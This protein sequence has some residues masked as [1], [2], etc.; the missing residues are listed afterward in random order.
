MSKVQFAPQKRSLFSHLAHSMC[1]PIPVL[2]TL[3]VGS[4]PHRTG[5]Q[6]PVASSSGTYNYLWGTMSWFP[7]STSLSMQLEHLCCGNTHKSHCWTGCTCQQSTT[8]GP[9]D[10]ECQR[11]KQP[12]IKQLGLGGSRPPKVSLSGLN[13]SRNRLGSCC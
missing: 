12:S 11:D 13:Q 5:T 10:Q 3:H 8:S 4:C 7:K 9:P 2:G 1:R 6:S